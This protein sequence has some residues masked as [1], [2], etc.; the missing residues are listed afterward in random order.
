MSWVYARLADMD[1]TQLDRRTPKG[2]LHFYL[3]S[4]RN[5][6]VWKTDGLSER[7][8]RTP[9]T[10]TGTNLLGIIK[11]CANVEAGY[12]GETFGRSWPEADEL[13][14]IAEIEADPQADWYATEDQTA[15]QIIDLYQR[16]WDFADETITELPLEAPGLVPWWPADRNQVTLHWILIHTTVDLARHAGHADILREGIDQTAGLGATNSNLPDVDW[17]AYVAKLRALAERF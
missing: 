15:Q 17:P 6:L 13:V 7:E 9:R 12:F 5:A 16:V 3:Q 14:S 4:V 10:P 11:H 2:A 8:L 1:I